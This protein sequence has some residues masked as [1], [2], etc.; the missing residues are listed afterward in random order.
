MV[1]PDT[2][3]QQADDTQIED[4]QTENQLASANPTIS[5]S[6]ASSASV[7]SSLRGAGL[8][9]NG[10]S[11]YGSYLL[12]S[13]RVGGSSQNTGEFTVTPTGGA[14][15]IYV[16]VGSGRSYT[17]H[18]LRF[19]RRPGSSELRAAATTGS[20]VCGTVASDQ[21]THVSVTLDAAS[22][23]FDVRIDG[24]TSAC[25]NLATR[26]L[27]PVVGFNLMDASNEGYGGRVEFRDLV[28]L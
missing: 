22:Q 26:L 16:L 25:T 2:E 17:T 20:V 12:A 23:T 13:Y 1:T 5:S 19:E 14:S 6:G 15:F 27:G 4:T 8:R 21:P 7:I 10:G 18:Q 28:V 24:A 9:I 11:D 3:D